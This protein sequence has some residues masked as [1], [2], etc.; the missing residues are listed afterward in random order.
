MYTIKDMSQRTGL[1]A[2]TFRYYDKIGL[3]K[4]TVIGMNGYRYYDDSVFDRLHAILLYRELEFSLT[5]IK[6]ILDDPG[7]DRR[8]ALTDQISVLEKKIAH[9]ESVL[10]QARHLQKGEETME[11]DVYSQEEIQA[12]QEEAKNRWGNTSAYQDFESKPSQPFGSVIKEMMDLLAQFGQLK[13]SS[14]QDEAV[15]DLV[16]AY[17]NYISEHFYPCSSEVLA[18]L[19]KMYLEDNRFSQVIDQT[20]GEGTAKFVSEAI[21]EYCRHN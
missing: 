18:G 15:Q 3:L 13:E 19:G 21:H 9:F 11:F 2:K 6:R 1:S 5:D 8:T 12:L 7:Y 4:P 20:G 17:Q 14:P 16:R 10:N